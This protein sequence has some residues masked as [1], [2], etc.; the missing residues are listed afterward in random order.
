[1][2]WSKGSVARVG[3]LVAFLAYGA[4]L[5]PLPYE[6]VELLIDSRFR[7]G[8]LIVVV[9]ALLV[10]WKGRESA[11]HTISWVGGSVAAAVLLNIILDSLKD[12]TTHNLAGLE[13]VAAALA[14]AAAAA[15][16]ALLG[17]LLQAPDRD[18]TPG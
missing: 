6:E 18:P 9:V 7:W 17:G 3:F 12:A 11:R 13:V 10:R 8:L 5:W 2:E 4:L 14:G 1:M 16:G 15:L